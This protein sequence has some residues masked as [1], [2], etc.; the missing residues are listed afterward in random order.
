MKFLMD[1][2]KKTKSMLLATAT[3]VQ[4]YPIEAWDLLEILSQKNDSVLGSSFSRWRTQTEKALNL[5]LGKEKF[6]EFDISIIDWVRDPFPPEN[7]EEINFGIIRRRTG[8]R[9]E[10]FVLTNDAINSL[11]V[12]DYRR[13]GRI[14]NN[15]FIQS[16]NPFIRHIVR[17]TRDFW[18]I[19]LILK[20]MS[21]I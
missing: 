13:L 11:P 4:L 3:P 5:L 18:K 21:L 2:S 17:R 1:I 15:N 12:P 8:M 16:Y 9:D 14:A 6:G 20:Q 10:D 7:E 19:L